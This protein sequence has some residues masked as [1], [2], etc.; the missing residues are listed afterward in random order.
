MQITRSIP[1]VVAGA[2]AGIAFVLSCSDD[3]PHSADAAVCDCPAAE[4]PL[5][6]RI[7]QVEAPATVPPMDEEGGGVI[8]PTGA[9]ALGGGCAASTGAVPEIIVQ[10]SIPGDLG[11]SCSWRNPTNQ[12]IAVRAIVRCL[13]PAP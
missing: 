11:W 6:D 12:P 13:K 7:V 8:C 2:I 9:I 10:Q 1:L 4:P 3:S 5:A